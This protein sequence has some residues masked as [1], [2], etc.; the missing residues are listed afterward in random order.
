MSER[1]GSLVNTWMQQSGSAQ[2]RLS[3]YDYYTDA[4]LAPAATS[5]G[6]VD[7]CS[8]DHT[9]S[10]LNLAAVRR[11]LHV[12]E[13]AGAWSSCSQALNDAYSCSDTLVSMVPLYSALLQ[14]NRRVLVYSGDVDGVVPTLA[15]WRWVQSVQGKRT[16]DNWRPWLSSTGQIGGWTM[17]W[18]AGGGQLVFATVRGAGHM[19]PAFQPLRAFEL[20]YSFLHNRSL[21]TAAL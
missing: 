18:A 11:A 6:A 14:D 10:Y 9:A 7:A 2:S 21:P 19:V 20:F 17:R 8:D 5:A 1:C 4:C 13:R 15:S 12:S 3:L 16:V